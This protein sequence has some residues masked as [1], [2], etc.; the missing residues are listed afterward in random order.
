MAALVAPVIVSDLYADRHDLVKVTDHRAL[1]LMPQH[2][3]EPI[4]GQH[5]LLQQHFGSVCR[6]TWLAPAI[7]SVPRRRL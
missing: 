2:M 5:L 4:A 7:R 6:S 1:F 3:D